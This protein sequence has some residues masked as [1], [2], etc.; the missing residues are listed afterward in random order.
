MTNTIT[1]RQPFGWCKLP[2]NILLREWSNDN[3]TL[4][5]YL[6]LLT[7]CDY[8]TNQIIVSVSRICEEIGLTTKQTRRAI[9]VLIRANEISK[10]RAN[11]NGCLTFS[12]IGTYEQGSQEKGQTESLERANE[13]GQKRANE[14]STLTNNNT[15]TY[16][17]A[18]EEKGQTKIEQKGQTSDTHISIIYNNNIN[19]RVFLEENET[20]KIINFYFY[21]LNLACWQNET[22]RFI[23]YNVAKGN[24][25]LS[26][27]QIKAMLRLWQV[28]NASPLMSAN[29]FQYAFALVRLAYDNENLFYWL[30]TAKYVLDGNE[31]LIQAT[32][33]QGE[34]LMQ[35][36]DAYFDGDRAKQMHEIIGK[37][38]YFI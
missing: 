20:K 36:F 10:E 26:V 37:E 2:R 5:V 21:S 25:Y 14:I 22:E 6:Y 17:Q 8:R 9:D 32:E 33:C 3:T 31:L 12:I 30:M 29:L 18:S 23:A 15:I 34:Q 19:K 27:E 4:R 35:V 13:I 28:K 24:S 38:I 7:N 16:E 11:E 1:D